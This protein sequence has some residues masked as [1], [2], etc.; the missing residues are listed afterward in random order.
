LA[1]FVVLCF[2]AGERDGNP[3]SSRGKV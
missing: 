2:T 1:M 3:E